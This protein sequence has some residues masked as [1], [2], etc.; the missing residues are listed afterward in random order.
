MT[1]IILFD[2][3]NN[4]MTINTGHCISSFI[5]EETGL[6]RVNELAMKLWLVM[7]KT[8]ANMQVLSPVFSHLIRLWLLLP[9]I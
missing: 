6:E 7:G 3:E 2:S 9:F 8:E 4:P 1:K 5:D